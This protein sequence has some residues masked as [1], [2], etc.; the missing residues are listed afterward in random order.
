[1]KTVAATLGVPPPCWALTASIT[2]MVLAK[3]FR[4]CVAK[5]RRCSLIAIRSF[6]I[7]PAL[8]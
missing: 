5:N 3:A 4:S 2:A 8:A 7:A 1:M 6:S